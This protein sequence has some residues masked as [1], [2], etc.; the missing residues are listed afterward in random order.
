MVVL[1]D[2]AYFG[3]K[4]CQ[5]TA[6]RNILQYKGLDLSEEMLL[7]LGGGIGFIYWYM[8]KMPAPFVGGR[9]G[10]KNEEFLTNMLERIGGSG[11]L[12]QTSSVT[13]GYNQLMEMLH[14]GEPVYTYVDM[15]YL[16]YM[17][18]PGDAHFGAHTI[19]VYGVDEE[20]DCVYISDRGQ[21]PVYVTV[22]ELKN[23][24]SSKFPPFPPQNK[25][26]VIEYPQQLKGLK[27]GITDALKE[28]CYAMINPP[29]SNFGLKGMKKWA[30]IVMK[31]PQQF[32]GLH[33]YGCLMNVFI[34]IEIGGSGG[35]AFRPMYAAFLREASV[36]LDNPGL[37][38]VA[39]VYEESGRIW[40]SIAEAAL[41]GSWSVLKRS[42]DLMVEKNNVFEEQGP[43]AL[44][45]MVRINA[46]LD[47]VMKKAEAELQ[48]KD[49]KPLLQDLQQKILAL[50]NVESMAIHKLEEV[51]K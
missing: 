42:R 5:T 11:T 20:N 47:D 44:E 1:E 8:K 43:K 39:D 22:E 25:I 2:F 14:A 28:C 18:L 10:G 3:G 30:K 51:I 38:E 6:L 26:L 33:L 45:R 36:I 50:Y 41:P 19:V 9:S 49:V 46:E 23:A 7:G 17:A 48:Q 27:E 13:K 35:S 37:L 24:R 34:Y 21:G 40:S 32:T 29:I 16:P 12:F 4:H 15:A 31:W